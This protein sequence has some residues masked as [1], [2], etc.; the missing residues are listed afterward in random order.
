MAGR[1]PQRD[2]EE[3][4]QRVSIA[5][6]VGE[7]VQL[8]TGGVGS[9]KGLCP[10]HDEKSP[11]F[12]VRPDQ[13]FYHCFGCGEGGDVY[14]FL[15]KMENITFYEAVEKC[16]SKISYQ[17]Q[18]ESGGRDDGVNRARLFAANEAAAKFFAEQLNSPEAQTART[19]LSARNFDKTAAEQFGI[20]YAPKGWSALSDAL[21]AQGF[22]ED[23]LIKVDL[24][25]AKEGK[26]Y[27][28]FR[29]RLIWPIRDA[30]NSVIGFGARKIY[31]DDPLAKYVNT[32]ETP[33]YHKS[34][35]LYGLDLAKKEIVQNRQVVVVEGYTDVMA[36]HLAGIKT[37]VATCGTA[38][39]D[40]HI[41]KINQ[42]FGSSDQAA[43]VIFTFD[44]DAAGQKAAMRAFESSNKFI[45]STFVAVGPDGLDPCDLRIQKGDAAVVAM[46]SS[47][48]PIY[49]FAI[50]Q[51]ILGHDLTSYPGRLSAATAAVTVLVRVKDLGAREEYVRILA[52]KVQLGA[53]E[54][55][56]L[57]NQELA[58]QRAQ[59]VQGSRRGD[60]DPVEPGFEDEAPEFPAPNLNDANT[61][62]EQEVLAVLL[63]LPSEWSIESLRQVCSEL[64]ATVSYSVVAQ[65]A[66]QSVADIN[67]PNW[68]EKVLSNSPEPLHSLIRSLAVKPLPISNADQAKGYAEGVIAAAVKKILV[69]NRAALISAL[70]LLDLDTQADQHMKL[71]RDLV[72]LEEKIRALP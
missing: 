47:R 50:D 30:T 25:V 4:K 46:I 16:A 19:F 8:K 1:I 36:C 70:A 58:K 48:R 26:R 44:P 40:D 35:V 14:K 68:V 45:A 21:K 11:S 29:G 24:I 27:D 15:Q 56:R 7:Y 52:A 23:E 38:F 43:A 60:L 57:L 5:E 33:I 42:L 17:I 6:I 55:N 51:K 65:A 67:S 20:G 13:G 72:A 22:S 59:A 18:Y 41:R 39:G 54:I 66:I 9:L 62:F 69:R 34:Q 28:K 10:F 3:I 32:S 61:R 37:A 12:N 71:Q 2:I 49:E 53:D 64:F 63:Q 31:E